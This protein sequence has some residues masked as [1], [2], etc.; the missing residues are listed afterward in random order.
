MNKILPFVF[1]EK[2]DDIHRQLSIIESYTKKWR[3]ENPLFDEILDDAGVLDAH[4][5][6]E[7][8]LS[9]LEEEILSHDPVE[10][11]LTPQDK[12]TQKYES[13]RG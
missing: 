6:Y 5:T 4:E 1:K 8:A 2:I 10:N 11:L 13:G 3:A 12:R 7:E 9:N